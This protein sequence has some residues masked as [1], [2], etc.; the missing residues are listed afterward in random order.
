MR[1]P[2]PRQRPQQ[3]PQFQH[4]E[5]DRRAPEPRLKPTGQ[6]AV[7]R[8]GRRQLR[9]VAGGKAQQIEDDHGFLLGA[10]P[11]RDRYRL[12]ILH[13]CLDTALH[14]IGACFS[15][16]LIGQMH[17]NAGNFPGKSFQSMV[18]LF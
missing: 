10:V 1:L 8:I 7:R 5:P 2:A 12:Q 15:C 11:C 9:I 18:D 4:L 6:H 3:G 13:P 16:I 14:I 17:F